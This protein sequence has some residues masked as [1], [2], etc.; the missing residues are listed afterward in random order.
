MGADIDFYSGVGKLKKNGARYDPKLPLQDVDFA[1]GAAMMIKRE[2]INNI[3]LLPDFYFLYCEEMDYCLRA[4]KSGFKVIITPNARIIHKTSST[5][6]KFPG[7][8]NYYFHRSRFIFLRLHASKIQTFIAFMHSIL[9]I[10]PQAAI[11]Y[12][13][14]KNMKIAFGEISNFLYGVL[15]GICLKTGATKKVN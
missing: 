10:F 5:L 6:K 12:G 13:K 2:V 15:D 9:V 1:S 3:G 8:K 4:K 11:E 14:K 7:I